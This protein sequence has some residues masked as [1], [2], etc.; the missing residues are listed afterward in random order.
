V[1]VILG[2][3]DIGEP[4]VPGRAVLL[5]RDGTRL[6]AAASKA[7]AGTLQSAERE[8]RA[9][10]ATPHMMA[11]EA[12]GF[13]RITKIC[14]IRR[15]SLHIRQIRQLSGVPECRLQWLGDM[16]TSIRIFC[17]CFAVCAGAAGV[18]AQEK[19][20]EAALTPAQRDTIRQIIADGEKETKA[21]SEALAQKLGE[22]AKA[23][24]RNLLSEKPDESVHAKLSGELA[25]A[26][27]GLVRTAIGAKL[28]TMGELAKV[29][30]PGQK[31]F[32]LGELE[33]PGANPDL[34]ELVKKA[35]GEAKK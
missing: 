29:F 4:E 3:H 10:Q 1:N 7:F 34:A 26:V 5:R 14:R 35:F 17:Y 23:I 18:Q 28:K 22:I 24:D 21:Q 32:L 12:H 30:T 15:E 9:E 6:R 2:A 27:A 19:G 31:K 16:M 13:T 20:P 25:D 33:K 11:T 8:Q